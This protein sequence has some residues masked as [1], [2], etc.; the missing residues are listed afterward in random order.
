[1]GIDPLTHKPLSSL[2]LT[3][4]QSQPSKRQQ[5]PCSDQNDES[6]SNEI[7]TTTT[8][9]PFQSE[10]SSN[11]EADNNDNDNDDGT[12]VDRDLIDYV[13]FSTD[14]VPL[15]QPHEIVVSCQNDNDNAP[16]SSS[17]SSSS[18]S[19]GSPPFLEDFQ[20]ADFELP[21]YGGGSD[22]MLGLCDYLDFNG[23]DLEQEFLPY[24]LF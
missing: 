3:D 13:S 11:Q 23:W 22:E 19:S 20:I 14:D 2:V 9:T 17:S 24:G 12:M 10:S 15:A 8:T 4:D 21:S 16:S 1:M 6:Q 5:G 18:F 7:S